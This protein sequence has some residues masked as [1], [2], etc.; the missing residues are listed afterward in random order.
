MRILVAE[1]NEISRFKLEG[2]LSSWDCDVVIARDGNEAWEQLSTE[3]A[4]KLV[5]LDW[6]MP[7]KDGAEICRKVRQKQEST[8]PYI[9]LLTGKDSKEDV[10]EGLR[11][12]AD[13]YIVKPFNIDILKAR[14]EAGRRVVDLQ[15]TLAKRID[16]LERAVNH[17]ERLEGIIPI[18]M[19][20]KKI[21]NDQ[22]SWEQMEKYIS[23]H[24]DTKFSHGIC[25]DC[26]QD[27]IESR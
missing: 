17:I 18:C 16:E 14:I 15:A 8:P 22:E 10:I 27:H 5:L 3:S 11:A 7:G 24:S 25:P 21:R 9:I 23:E 2:I 1:D 19:Y 26:Y 12:G 6:K 20:C 13:D 4:P